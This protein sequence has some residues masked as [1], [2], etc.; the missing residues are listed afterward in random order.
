MKPPSRRPFSN[1]VRKFAAGVLFFAA[2]GAGLPAATRPA[3][4]TIFFVP[5]AT[6]LTQEYRD[7]LPGIC[8]R[9]AEAMA[10]TVA[11][12]FGFLTWKPRPADA[13]GP[14]DSPAA[15]LVTLVETPRGFGNEIT[16]KLSYRVG[17]SVT[18]V[19]AL[20]PWRLYAASSV[21]QPVWDP[22]A[23]EQDVT[24][25]VRQWLADSVVQPKLQEQFFKWIPIAGDFEPD[26]GKQQI[27]LPILWRELRA[28]PDSLLWARFRSR[29]NGSAEGCAMEITLRPATPW[30][31]GVGC[32]VVGFDYYSTPPVRSNAWDHV[33][34]TSYANRVDGSVEVYMRQYVQD[35]DPRARD[36]IIDQVP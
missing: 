24:A 26:P 14:D 22:A 21:D 31:G 15:L 5:P 6:K 4:T 2:A 16:L 23:F 29:V 20:P 10:Q 7:Q 34:H 27:I 13:S 18:P 30:S 11:E 36:G 35:Y 8:A 9:V 1:R 33:I 12:P 19:A 17:R 25:A 3:V 32:R 28:S